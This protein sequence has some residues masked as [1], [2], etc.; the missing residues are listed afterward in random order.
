MCFFNRNK[1]SFFRLYSF[2]NINIVLCHINS[3]FDTK[4]VQTNF[5]FFELE[6]EDVSYRT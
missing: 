2:I 6:F 4:K 1:N 3:L 5:D